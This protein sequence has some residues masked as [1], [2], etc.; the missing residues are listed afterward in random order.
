MPASTHDLARRR[1]LQ[2][3]GAT[4]AWLSTS[5]NRLSREEVRGLI[6]RQEA[7]Y[8]AEPPLE[9]LADQW[10]TPNELM[11][12]RSHGNVP[13]IDAATY[14]LRI[15]GLVERPL[16][17]SLEQLA[18][19]GKAVKNHA[20][21]TCAGNRR[22]EL[23][24]IKKISGVQWNAGAIGNPEWEGITLR[25]VLALAHIKPEA[26]HVWFDGLDEVDHD[27]HK[28]AFGGSIP[29]WKMSTNEMPV[30]LATKMNGQPLTPQHGYPL[31]VVVPGF[32]G[33]RS[34]KWLGKIVVSDRPSPN[35]FLAETYKLV[36][37]NDPEEMAKAEPLYRTVQNSAICFPT[38]GASIKAGKV[39][40][41]GYA[42]PPGKQ[43]TTIAKVEVSVDGGEWQAAKLEKADQPYC[44]ALWQHA[45]ELAPGKHT[46]RVRSIDNVNDHQPE[47]PAWNA[48]GYMCNSW[49]TIEVEAA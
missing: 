47:K 11:F 33:A 12:I 8:N 9:K 25:D 19:A 31:R 49:H 14:R 3:S 13:E 2:L 36:Q 45:V 48:K 21:L 20:V 5:R 34:V 37:T 35:H 42:L 22:D 30:L 24:A 23:S 41:K 7:P 40:L 39:Q 43:T 1:F 15:E 27:G 44:W 38:P 16:E 4:L 17:L 32:I 10:T 29:L 6:T 26:K 18:K 46:L 28:I